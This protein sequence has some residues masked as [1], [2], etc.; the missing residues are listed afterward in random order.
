[1]KEK[2]CLLAPGMILFGFENKKLNGIYFDYS[3][4][5]SINVPIYFN[6]YKKLIHILF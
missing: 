4:Q 6:K 2:I 5:I 3:G 1:M